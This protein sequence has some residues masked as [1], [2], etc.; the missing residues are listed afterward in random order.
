MSLPLPTVERIN[1]LFSYDPESGVLRWRVSPA[2][3]VK[4]GAVA[5]CPDS[6]GYLVV[7]LDGKRLKV[8][9]VIWLLQTGE[10]P[11]AEIDHI[12]GIRDDNRFANLRQATRQEN[13]CNSLKHAN[14]TSGYK[15]VHW[16]KGTRKWR[17]QVYEGGKKFHLGLFETPEEAHAA[18]VAE[19]QKR[20]GVFANDGVAQMAWPAWLTA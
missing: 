3:N 11:E 7:Q 6:C 16:D 15:G 12:N 9:R 8:H 20:H 18:Y 14:N 17:A 4:A 5:G 19:A 1:E 2:R 13:K 10:W